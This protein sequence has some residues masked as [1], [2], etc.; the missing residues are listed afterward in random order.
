MY[1]IRMLRTFLRELT[2]QSNTA[3]SL[4]TRLIVLSGRNTRSTRKDFM[5]LRFWPVVLPL[6]VT[7]ISTCISKSYLTAGLD[8]HFENKTMSDT[9]IHPFKEFKLIHITERRKHQNRT[10]LSRCFPS[11][12]QIILKMQRDEGPYSKYSTAWSRLLW[13]QNRPNNTVTNIRLIIFL[14]RPIFGF[15]QQ[16][17]NINLTLLVESFGFWCDQEYGWKCQHKSVSFGV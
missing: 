7:A 10:D 11:K 16:H 8:V 2:T 13:S 3:L 9:I 15:H 1:T 17:I 12:L 14:M 4:G 5:V 6:C